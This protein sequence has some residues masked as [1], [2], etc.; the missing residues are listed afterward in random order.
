MKMT[1]I[2]IDELLSLVGALLAGRGKT[3]EAVDY[4]GVSSDGGI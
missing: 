1:A 4:F 2:Q 3:V